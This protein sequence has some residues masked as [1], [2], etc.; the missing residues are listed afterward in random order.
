MKPLEWVG[1]SYR[2]LTDMPEKIQ[3]RFGYA[4][5]VAQTGGRHRHAKPMQGFGGAAV[6]EVIENFDGDTYRAVY[7]V[8]FEEAIYVLHVFQKKSTKGIETPKRDVELIKT[9]LREAEERRGR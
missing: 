6:L 2:D 5:W 1:S 9:R 3:N 4:L 7:T 8:K